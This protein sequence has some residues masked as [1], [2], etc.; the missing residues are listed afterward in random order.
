[1]VTNLNAMSLG[2]TKNGSMQ[3]NPAKTFECILNPNSHAR[4]CA[5]SPVSPSFFHRRSSSFTPLFERAT[6]ELISGFVSVGSSSNASGVSHS[7]G[8]DRSGKNACGRMHQ[9]ITDY[10]CAYVTCACLL[11]LSD[12]I[13]SL[14]PNVSMSLTAWIDGPC[15]KNRDEHFVS[16]MPRMLSVTMERCIVR[17]H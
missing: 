11:K 7:T 14:S 6:E 16:L 13:L 4:T 10:L 3:C 5:N 8:P 12:Y 2:A 17:C 15:N 1:M 9:N